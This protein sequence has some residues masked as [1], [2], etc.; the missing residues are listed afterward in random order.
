MNSKNTLSITE[1]RKRIFEIAEETQK[2]DVRYTITEKG[3]PKMVMLSAEEYESLIEDLEIM[4]DPGFAKRVKKVEEEIDRG[5][6]ITWEEMKKELDQLHKH[7]LVLADRG[8]K[9]YKTKKHK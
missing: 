3:K 5:E 4:S 7:D 8:K 9:K 6:Y 2:P 1:A